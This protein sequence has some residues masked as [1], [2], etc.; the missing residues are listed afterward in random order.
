MI[1]ALLYMFDYQ[2]RPR[3]P[4][5]SVVSDY[6]DRSDSIMEYEATEYSTTPNQQRVKQSFET[7]FVEFLR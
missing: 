2:A 3:Q 4:S 7:K 1:T 6:E 5:Q